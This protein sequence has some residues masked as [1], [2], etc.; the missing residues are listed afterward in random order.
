[1][2]ESSEEEH[3]DA[4]NG[5]YSSTRALIV[6]GL[7]LLIFGY[8]AVG[9]LR[10]LILWRGD[11]TSH[12]TWYFFSIHILPFC[13]VYVLL[14]VLAAYLFWPNR[15]VA[16][17]IWTVCFV[18]VRVGPAIYRNGLK[19]LFYPS[20]Q[21]HYLLIVPAVIV[22]YAFSRILLGKT[23]V[24][25][26]LRLAAVWFVI[27]ADLTF[28]GAMVATQVAYHTSEGYAK[29]TRMEFPVPEG[30]KNATI[31]RNRLTGV[32][33]LSFT[34]EEATGCSIYEFYNS[35]FARKG[36]VPSMEPIFEADRSYARNEKEKKS[37]E[38]IKLI[39]G[40]M[41]QKEEIMI[42]VYARLT[43]RRDSSDG[44][45]E[46]LYVIVA[47]APFSP[48]FPKDAFRMKATPSNPPL[49]PDSRQEN[50]N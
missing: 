40:W 37:L 20:L 10:M 18:T 46:E 34:S 12:I 7:L 3:N 6:R 25:K 1:M 19:I 4:G 49:S 27:V 35:A 24:G 44:K 48:F 32:S 2:T 14:G 38:A 9:W 39:A 30:A 42:D 5:P 13:A 29:A 8:F 45:A 28:V 41:D 15:S 36:Y 21:S 26:N 17:T 33:V 11:M 50:A 23:L 31:K 47:A 16:L 43:P 22:G